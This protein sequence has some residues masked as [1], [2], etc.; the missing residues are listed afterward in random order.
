MD[1]TA[2]FALLEE[3]SEEG[4]LEVHARGYEFLRDELIPAL[5]VADDG[6][7]EQ[8]ELVSDGWYLVGDIHD[9]NDA[10]LAA[11]A[12]YE[13]SAK[14]DPDSA[15]PHREMAGAFSRLGR[16][17]EALN[18]IHQAMDLDPAVPHGLS[19]LEDIQNAAD[20]KG[21]S[22]HVGGDPMWESAESLAGF[23]PKAALKLVAELATLEG[24]QMRSRCHGALDQ[25]SK[26]LDAWN[27]IAEMDGPIELGYAD[28]FYMPDEAIDDLRFWRLLLSVH[29]RMEPGVFLHP[30]EEVRNS[31]RSLTGPESEK[32]YM[33]YSIERLDGNIDGLKAILRKY[34]EWSEIKDDIRELQG[35]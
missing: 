10:P 12:A 29:D 5:E 32:L 7:I 2:A 4:I 35:G 9:F 20:G 3:L 21:P 1:Y 16:H 30:P 18:A 34:P 14:A 28:W 23:D 24:I 26:F 27:E 31:H 8:A 22:E 11:I 17:A 25:A 6:S 19:D 13:R 15:A 33:E